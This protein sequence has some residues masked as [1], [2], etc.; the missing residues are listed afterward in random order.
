M[1]HINAFILEDDRFYA[2]MVSAHLEMEGIHTRTFN[3]EQLCLNALRSS[4]PDL[5]VLDHKLENSTGLEILE[6]VNILRRGTNV[7][8]LSA[9]DRYN[10]V[11]KALKYGAV[12]Y[13][14]K[15]D[16]AFVQ[17]NTVIGKLK[18]HTQNFKLPLNLNQYRLDTDFKVA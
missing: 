15:G 7:I 18:K 5:L 13:V 2:E 8:Y 10:V 3:E 9:Q 4:P 14:E 6:A 16:G 17:L 11:L 12:D 1:Q